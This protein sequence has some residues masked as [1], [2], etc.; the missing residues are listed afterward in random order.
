M[1]I[2]TSL[3]GG[4]A[5]GALLAFAVA[6]A[7]FAATANH[8]RHPR[9]VVVH[10]DAAVKG[11][12]DELKAEVD[13]LKAQEEQQAQA[14][15]QTQA[16]MQQMQ[17]QLQAAN[18]RA[19]QA[20]AQVQAQIQTIP[21]VVDQD[22]T[23]HTPKT[24][25]I[26][27]KGITLTL[28]GF[29]AAESVYRTR[30]NVSDIGSNYSKIPYHNSELAHTDELRFTGRQSRV[31]FLAQGAINPNLMASFYG[32]F[33]FLAAPTTANSNESNSFSPR[34]RHVYGALDWNDTGW[35]FLFGQNW[36]LVTMN[37]KGIT[38][39]NE[40]I[41]AT[42]EAQY[43]PGFVWA[44]Q[45]QLRV[46]HDFDDKQGWIA[47]SVENPQTTFA[48]AATG[49]STTYGGVIANTAGAGIGLLSSV[50]NFSFNHFPDV[51]GKVAFEPLIDGKQPLHL[52]LFGLVRD[53]YDRVNIAAASQANAAGLATGN[54]SPNSWGGGVG[55]G[56]T[57][58]AVPGLLDVQGSALTGR[59]IGRYGSGQLPDVIV[60]PGGNLRPI[61]ETMFLFGGTVHATKELDLYAYGGEEFQGAVASNPVVGPTTLHLGYGNPFASLGNCFVE[62][63]GNNPAAVGGTAAAS[64]NCSPDTKS[65]SQVTVG[66]WDKLYTGSFG[67]VR[68]GI[69]YSHTELRAFPGLAG[70]NNDGLAPGSTVRPSTSDDM[71]FTSFRYYPF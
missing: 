25:K 70:T 17:G 69:Q 52:E 9:V 29:A 44:R 63:P 30:N 21:G 48:S 53:F 33:D 36:S 40:V 55:G 38:Q 60:G 57:W 71:V 20:E 5:L 49:T 27:Y 15:A 1:T 31:S 37:N 26:Y 39:R 7:G 47:L 28:G 62:L 66:V 56:A 34:I 23:A 59:G 61:D 24:D 8:H 22:V 41:P 14:A 42:I 68:V 65:I 3:L 45:P 11:E 35:H 46:T 58:A 50:N 10:D 43:V 13:A 2:R 12:V 51:V 6:P 18:A 4:A 32:E 64:N 54:Y 19:D 67:Q 16:Q